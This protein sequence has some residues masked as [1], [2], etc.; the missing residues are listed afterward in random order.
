MSQLIIVLGDVTDH[1]GRVITAGTMTDTNGL[2]WARMGDMV[3][4]PRCK[5]IYPI[6]Q[7]DA[8]FIVDGA[9]VAYAGCEVACGAKLIGGKQGITATVPHGG[10][11]S[12]AGGGLDD[13]FGLISGTMAAA[14]ED[15]PV[16]SE[17]Q[18]FKG[19]FQVL[20]R[21]TGEPVAATSVR[22][23][24]TDGQYLT[25]QT[26]S[27]GYTQWVERDANEALGFDLVISAHLQ[28][29]DTTPRFGCPW[30]PQRTQGA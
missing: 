7:G 3:S 14:Y 23:R 15:E 20:D 26:D 6:A 17:G 22:V 10:A 9:P 19:R 21:I 24:S 16:D 28:L 2:P 18:R 25:G 8:N 29:T 30:R 27:E 5:G 1:G 12:G 11:G 4:C 13:R